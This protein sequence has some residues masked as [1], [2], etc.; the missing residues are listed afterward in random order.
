MS[1]LPPPDLSKLQ[2]AIELEQQ[3]QDDECTNKWTMGVVR[4]REREGRTIIVALVGRGGGTDEQGGKKSGG[5]G[6]GGGDAAAGG[7][8]GSGAPGL[9]A[10]SFYAMLS[11]SSP[12]SVSYHWNGTA[13][14]VSGWVEEKE[15]TDEGEF[16]VTARLAK[17]SPLSEEGI[18]LQS[19]R[20]VRLGASSS[21]VVTNRHREALRWFETES[22]NSPSGQLLRAP[23]DS[24]SPARVSDSLVGELHD[25]HPHL[26][27]SQVAAVARAVGT[28]DPLAVIHGPPG[29]GKST[30][31]V[32]VIAERL[33]LGQR[34]L[35]AAPSN[36]AVD[37]LAERVMAALPAAQVVRVGHVGRQSRAVRERCSLDLLLAESDDGKLAWEARRRM[38]RLLGSL[39]T[40]AGRDG[41]TRLPAKQWRERKE[42]FAQLREAQR[43]LRVLEERAL[44]DVLS[45]SQVV[46]ATLA[47]CGSRTVLAAGPFD[48][49]IIDEA[50]Q[51]TEP[52]A[53]LGVRLAPTLILAGDHLQLAP[54]VISDEAA[55][56]GLAETL[57]SRAVDW[58]G[59][60]AVR[61]L[62]LQ[63]RM[64][65]VIADFASAAVYGGRL[66]TAETVA[67]RR[68]TDLPGVTGP[69]ESPLLLVDTAGMPGY[70]ESEV[71]LRDGSRANEGE[72]G[73]VATRVGQ[74]LAR[75]VP[76]S[77]IGVISPYAGQVSLVRTLVPA[78]VEVST[79]DGFQGREKGVIL[80]TLVRANEARPPEVGFLADARRINVAVTRPKY[81]LW[82]IGQSTTVS[83]APLIDALFAYAEEM[84]A[85]IGVGQ[86]LADA[87]AEASR[88]GGVAMKE[89]CRCLSME[90]VG[91]RV[92]MRWRLEQPRLLLSERWLKPGLS[93]LLPT[94]R[95]RGRQRERRREL[96]RE[97][98]RSEKQRG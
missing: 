27:D 52:E 49:V 80:L 29:T 69:P 66:G 83:A 87:D 20:S 24:W 26:N 10:S 47:G 51:A 1:V 71:E 5:K 88:V 55:S 81:H 96:Q 3:A 45:S 82:V 34:L 16:I 7:D 18:A 54:T 12:L 75:G 98:R 95:R 74:L 78:G 48:A 46:F 13:M 28:P 58:Y 43:D 90:G 65:I 11:A 57:L 9:S 25:R 91:S 8:G 68:L 63:Y 72:A 21:T 67:H 44:K 35:V 64:N 61:M 4:G 23:D 41:L 77:E 38:R 60:R 76:A 6:K 42:R 59:D 86:F 15:E 22:V 79:V 19:V 84:D 14:R 31:L 17:V 37:T 56:L 62:T 94:R 70:E 73:A 32:S 89:T 92:S 33:R 53:W 40:E 50:A 39:A 85:V 2:R 97:R 30:T 93:S 36:L